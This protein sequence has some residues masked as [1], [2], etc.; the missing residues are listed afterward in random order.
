MSLDGYIADEQAGFAWITGDGDK[1]NDTEAFDFEQFFSQMDTIVMGRKAFDDCPEESL[2]DFS[3][4]RI[5]VA[6]HSP[7]QREGIEVICGD[8]VNKVL[9]MCKEEQ[10]WIFGGGVLA[11]AFIKA[12]VIDEYIVGIIPTIL[13]EGIKLFHGNNPTIP[14]HLEE[15]TVQEGIVIMKYSKRNQK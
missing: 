2:K 14:L 15:C 9:E 11:D 7:L 12:D 3:K 8:V 1:G 6:S 4:K 10:V 5:I 13:G